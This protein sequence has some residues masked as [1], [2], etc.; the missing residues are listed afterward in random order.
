[1]KGLSKFHATKL[2]SRGLRQLSERE[3]LRPRLRW[4]N[5]GVPG[6][7]DAFTSKIRDYME[8]AAGTALNYQILYTTPKGQNYTPTGGAAYAKNQRDTNMTQGGFLSNP[9]KFMV[10]GLSCSNRGDI[11]PSDWNQFFFNTL[12]TFYV[13]TKAYFECVPLELPG[14]G[15]ASGFSQTFQAA[16]A[17]ANYGSVGNGL[18]D[19]RAILVLEG[20][21]WIASLQN[22]SVVLDPTLFHTGAFTTAAAGG[23]TFGT[24]IKLNF[25][26]EGILVGPVL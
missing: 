21:E 16:A 7:G 9:R 13:D 14:G 15:G 22:F 8:V 25:N 6:I 17:N 2:R 23:T 24:G 18:P 1:M 10:K 12:V 4:R 11:A 3:A 26:I 5:A 20:Q 19:S